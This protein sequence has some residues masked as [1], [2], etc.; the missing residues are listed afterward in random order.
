MSS[1]VKRSRDISVFRTQLRFLI[2]LRSFR[3]DTIHISLS[4]EPSLGQGTNKWY[5]PCA[6]C[7]VPSTFHPSTVRLRAHAEALL[8]FNSSALTLPARCECARDRHCLAHPLLCTA[9]PRF[10]RRFR[11]AVGLRKPKPD[12]RS[13]Y[14]RRRDQGGLESEL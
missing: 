14:L 7:P 9:Q 11:M 3:N 6:L 12:R 13:Q 1:E 2:T 8:R 5:V 4:R 10:A